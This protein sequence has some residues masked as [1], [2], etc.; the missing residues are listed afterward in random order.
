MVTKPFKDIDGEALDRL[1]V[2]VAEAKK[3]NLAL[4]LPDLVL[5][6]DALVTLE[7]LQENIANQDITI[8]KLRKLSGIERSSES[9][10]TLRDKKQLEEDIAAELANDTDAKPA[11]DA[12]AEPA[13]DADAE[14]AKDTDAE[15]AKDADAEPA[16]EAEATVADDNPKKQP[17][18]KRRKKDRPASPEVEPEVVF[19]PM[20]TRGR[21]DDCPECFTGKVYAYKENASFLR[22]TGNSPFTPT[23]HEMERFGCNTCGAY[24]TAPLPD[25]VSMDGDW[26]QK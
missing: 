17:K 26:G 22:I 19:H 25:E 21:G 14:P 24:F 6:L 15:P 7:I 5:I 18:K 1:N 16:K 20:K 3:H 9:L 23:R 13:K 4:E 8:R 10:Q 12:E 2:R 11:T